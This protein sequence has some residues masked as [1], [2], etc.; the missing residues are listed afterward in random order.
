MADEQVRSRTTRRCGSRCGG[1]C[2]SKSMRRRTCSRTSRAAAG[3]PGRRLA[4]PAGHGPGVH[5]RLPRVDRGPRAVHRGSGGRARPRGG[6][7]QYVMLGA[8][9]DTFAQR[10]PEL[11]AR[12]RVFEIDQPGPQA[13]KRQRLVDLGFGV[14]AWLRLV[15]VDFE[16]GDAWWE[17]LAAAGFDAAAARGRGL[18]RRQ[19]VPDQGRERGDAAPGR[20]ARAGLDARDDVHA[21]DRAGRRAGPAGAGA[22]RRTA[23]GPRARRSSASSRPAEM[24]A[25][26]REAG[27]ARGAARVGGASSTTATS[28]GGPDGLRM[29]TGEDMLV[30]TV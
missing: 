14:P 11:A 8:G 18:H 29:S 3:G 1:R 26:A 10:R 16:A 21:S 27:F 20:D 25:L 28:P 22:W 13:W 30:A 23:R 6:V 15:P 7:G 2:T 4:R 19:H 12:L 24:L 5:P 9:L 17:R